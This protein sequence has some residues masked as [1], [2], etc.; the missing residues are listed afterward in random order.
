MSDTEIKTDEI[1]STEFR[2]RN[3]N[4]SSL[5]FGMSQADIEEY[6]RKEKEKKNP[7]LIH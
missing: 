5:H 7:A 2:S 6:R 1:E 4:G 3:I